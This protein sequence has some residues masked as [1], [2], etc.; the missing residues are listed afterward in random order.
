MEIEC[1]VCR[2]VLI[3]DIPYEWIEL[4]EAAKSLHGHEP[5]SWRRLNL[6][7]EAAEKLTGERKPEVEA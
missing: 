6:A 2:T 4:L 7:I 3:V 5:K 1:S